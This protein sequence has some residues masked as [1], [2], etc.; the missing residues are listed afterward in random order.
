MLSIARDGGELWHGEQEEDAQRAEAVLHFGNES[1]AG[2]PVHLLL[3]SDRQGQKE[4]IKRQSLR[5]LSPTTVLTRF[6]VP[7]R[8]IERLFISLVPQ[9]KINQIFYIFSL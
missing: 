9:K 6:W 2:A 7:R 5:Y 1:G 3:T 4:R 8:R